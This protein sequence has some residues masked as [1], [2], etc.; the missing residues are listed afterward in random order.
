MSN[1]S[2]MVDR[3]PRTAVYSL[4]HSRKDHRAVE[5][6]RAFCA[7]H[8]LRCVFYL[9]KKIPKE[10]QPSAWQLLLE[11][12]SDGRFEGVITW[13]QLERMEQFCEEHSTKYLEV[14]IFDWFQA[15]R[16][17]KVNVMRRD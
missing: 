9:D 4:L 7:I 12:V 3:R 6:L 1:S 17:A 15:M 5:L 13:L 14:D 10:G 8:G 11:D 16:A 2:N